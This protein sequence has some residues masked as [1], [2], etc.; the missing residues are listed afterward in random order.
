MWSP[1]MNRA[2][3]T[4]QGMPRCLKRPSDEPINPA[5]TGRR[6]GCCG[7]VSIKNTEWLRTRESS[8]HAEIE[9][10]RES[11]SIVPR[12]SSG[13]SRSL[14]HQ[15]DAAVLRSPCV[16][17][18]GSHWSERAD[19]LRVQTRSCDAVLCAQD[20]HYRVGTAVRQIQVSWKLADVVGVPDHMQLEAEFCCSSLAIS[21]RAASD[22]GLTSALPVSK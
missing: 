20:F 12:A 10:S 15:L 21:F 1:T 11:T 2:V 5:G 19:A 3:E 9:M 18:V 14:L 13:L 8:R 22:S 6:A 7:N 17:V 16:A 4:C